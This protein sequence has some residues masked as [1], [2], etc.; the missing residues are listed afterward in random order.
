M[1]RGTVVTGAV[2]VVVAVVV[3]ITAASELEHLVELKQSK[4]ATSVVDVE[5]ERSH[6]LGLSAI[7]N[8]MAAVRQERSDAPHIRY[9][10][11]PGVPRVWMWSTIVLPEPSQ[12]LTR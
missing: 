3:V 4:H 12:P 6:G 9:I 8:H 1:G 5:A 2:V 11:R 10:R 7:N